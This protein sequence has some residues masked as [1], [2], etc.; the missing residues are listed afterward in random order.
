MTDDIN[1]QNGDFTWVESAA[2]LQ[3]DA[4]LGIARAQR[5]L[6]M[7]YMRGRGVLKDEAIAFY[8]MT[9]AAQQ[10]FSLAQR[11]LGELYEKGSGV[12]PDIIVASHWYHL[13]ALQG[14]SI[15]KQHFQRLGN[16]IN[17]FKE[18]V[19]PDKEAP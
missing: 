14:D 5:L 11:S 9:L 16:Q 12:A 4:R 2:V 7:R 17:C 6:A 15:A 19:N 3:T 8:W 18:S 1:E 10:N 13:A